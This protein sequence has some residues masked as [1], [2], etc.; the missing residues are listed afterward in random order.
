M[1][2]IQL[3]HGVYRSNA[4]DSQ[5]GVISCGEWIEKEIERIEGKGG[6]CEIRMTGNK[7]ELWVVPTVLPHNWK[8]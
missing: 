2:M 1:K 3:Y 5:Y 4:I 6:V 8:N 7:M